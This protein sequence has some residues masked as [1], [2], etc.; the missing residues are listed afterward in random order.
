MHLTHSFSVKQQVRA[1]CIAVRKQ[2]QWF[3]VADMSHVH[4]KE[5]I[6]QYVWAVCVVY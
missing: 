5:K 6:I 1:F 3:T 2:I 4:T